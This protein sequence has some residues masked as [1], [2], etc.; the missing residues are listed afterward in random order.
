VDLLRHKAVSAHTRLPETSVRDADVV[1]Q[2]VVDTFDA[3]EPLN[4][5]IRSNVGSAQTASGRH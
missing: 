3:C 1:R 4:D 2:F 5:W